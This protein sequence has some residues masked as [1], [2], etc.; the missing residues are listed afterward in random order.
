V[1]VDKVNATFVTGEC[2]LFALS[3]LNPG[4]L[5]K[6]GPVEGGCKN[7]RLAMLKMAQQSNA[8]NRY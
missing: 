8:G 6:W 7:V 2:N 5:C 3:R 1:A 4:R